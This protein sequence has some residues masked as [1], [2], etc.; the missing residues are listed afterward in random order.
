MA[1]GCRRTGAG[2]LALCLVGTGNCTVSRGTL[3]GWHR[4]FWL[5]SWAWL[6]VLRLPAW[7]LSKVAWQGAAILIGGIRLEGDFSTF[8]LL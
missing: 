3:K 1:S 6:T 8:L 5:Q 4:V 2:S 7:Q